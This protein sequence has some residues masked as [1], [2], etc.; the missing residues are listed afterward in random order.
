MMPAALSYGIGYSEFWN[1]TYREIKDFLDFSV[2]KGKAFLERK[3]KHSLMCAATT[4]YYSGYY[5]RVRNFPS[6]LEKAFPKLFGLTDDGCIPVEN[7]QAGLEQMHRIAAQHNAAW[8][9]K[10]GDSK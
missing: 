7:W 5:S 4:A 10:G 3:E 6:S 8:K 1:M 2:K 9:K